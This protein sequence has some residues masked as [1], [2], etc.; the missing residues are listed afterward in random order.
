MSHTLGSCPT[1]GK[2]ITEQDEIYCSVCGTE[3][4]EVREQSSPVPDIKPKPLATE[5]L[6]NKITE[7]KEE[8]QAFQP[9]LGEAKAKIILKRGGVLTEKTF[10]ISGKQAIIGRFDPDSGPVDIDLSCLEAAE[11]DYLSRHHAKIWCNDFGEWFLKDLGSK[12]GS[13]FRSP[14]DLKFER[15]T[16]EQQ[17]RKGYEIALGNVQFE[18]C[19]DL[20]NDTN[21]SGDIWDND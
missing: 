21:D 18:F 2:E 4:A 15:V 8:H 17:I 11:V 7:Q 13:F 12:N 9:S 5:L 6:T 10:L 1:C 20:R 16:G 19:Q 3:L 14:P